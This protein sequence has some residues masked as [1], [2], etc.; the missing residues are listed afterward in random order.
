MERGHH[1][2]GVRPERRAARRLGNRRRRT[3][4]RRRAARPMPASRGID[5]AHR[6]RRRCNVREH[7]EGVPA[8]ARLALRRTQVGLRAPAVAAVGVTIGLQ[9]GQ[10]RGGLAAS[11]RAAPS[12][13][14]RARA[15]GSP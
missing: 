3:E 5:V 4:G 1:Q 14:G 2:V 13:D 7:L 9:R 6:I 12:D 8:A 10:S 15:R 11:K